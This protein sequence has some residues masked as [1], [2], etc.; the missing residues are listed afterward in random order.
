M[1]NQWQLLQLIACTV[2]FIHHL[3]LPLPELHPLPR[4]AFSLPGGVAVFLA[5]GAA[6]AAAASPGSPAAVGSG[7]D[8]LERAPATPAG[9]WSLQAEDVGDGL[10]GDEQSWPVLG[11]V[12][13]GENSIDKA[14]DGHVL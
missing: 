10:G 2:R 7:V 12:D 1:H 13:G 14:G 4:G 11:Q 3:P 8:S 9:G 6:S 5:G